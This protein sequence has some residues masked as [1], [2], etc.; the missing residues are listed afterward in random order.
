MPSKTQTFAEEW[1]LGRPGARPRAD[2]ST[3]EWAERSQTAR[4]R[5]R[6]KCIALTCATGAVVGG[7]LFASVAR[8]ANTNDP[9]DRALSKEVA[10]LTDFVEHVREMKFLHP[11]K[12]RVVSRTQFESLPNVDPGPIRDYLVGVYPLLRPLG[13][14]TGGSDPTPIARAVA[15]DEDG[16]YDSVS[17]TIVVRSDPRES[18]V[19]KVIVHELTHALDDQHFGIRRMQNV[20]S[21]L[22]DGLS[23]DA[24]IEGD[25]R[26][27]EDEYVASLSSVSRRQSAGASAVSSSRIPRSIQELVLFP[28]TAGSAFVSALAVHGG[29]TAVNDAFRNPPEW[30]HEVFHPAAYLDPKKRLEVN[31]RI[32]RLAAP[33]IVGRILGEPDQARVAGELLTRMFLESALPTR[34]ASIAAGAWNGDREVTWFTGDQYCI[35][36][37]YAPP[38]GN[39]IDVLGRAVRAWTKHEPHATFE[40]RT[41]L[42]CA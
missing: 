42:A 22:G 7:V 16:Y 23:V 6:R 4:R 36:I 33:K 38:N 8:T 14:S 15:L 24:L 41:L 2:E 10:Q 5:L 39:G 28:Y 30:T 21:K 25:A 20:A 11:V 19:Q 29:E 13:L 9:R 12:V 27:V 17:N 1:R 18:V 26:R 37:T 3:S 32:R 34:I 35:R 31:A 40:H